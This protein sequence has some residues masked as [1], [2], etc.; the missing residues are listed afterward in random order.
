MQG[1]TKLSDPSDGQVR[2][3]M[4]GAESAQDRNSACHSGT[5]SLEKPQ[6]SQAPCM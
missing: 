5:R 6:A 3:A 2:S 1:P 4:P